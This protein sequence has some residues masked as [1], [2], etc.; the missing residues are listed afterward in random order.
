MK[1]LGSPEFARVCRIE[2]L[3]P[4]ILNDDLELSLNAARSPVAA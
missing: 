3:A 4:K 2:D 1:I